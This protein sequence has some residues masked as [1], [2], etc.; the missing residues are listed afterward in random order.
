VRW[1]CELGAARVFLAAE[2][3]GRRGV[4]VVE[5]IPLQL[6][7][8]GQRVYSTRAPSGVSDPGSIR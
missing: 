6:R 1:Q 7:P 5:T 3:T 2:T 8:G 4:V